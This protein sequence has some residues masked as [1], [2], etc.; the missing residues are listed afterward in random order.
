M[1]RLLVLLL[2]DVRV[3]IGEPAALAAVAAGNGG[4]EHDL[5]AVFKLVGVAA[6]EADVFVVDV[7]VDEAAEL[8]MLVLD[9]LGERGV[10]G[11]DLGEQA[12]KVRGGGVEGL[13]A[14][15]MAGQ[16]GGE[17]DFDGHCFYLQKGNSKGDG[18]R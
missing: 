7:D 3:R 15:R 6:E 1:E 12:G 5:V 8:A 14:F 4:D 16:G 13:L 9:V 17:D 18:E 11:V 10:P 2:D